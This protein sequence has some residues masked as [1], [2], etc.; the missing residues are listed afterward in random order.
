MSFYQLMKAD[1]YFNNYVDKSVSDSYFNL[2]KNF[3]LQVQVMEVF[4]VLKDKLLS[5]KNQY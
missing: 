4:I 3:E 5:I 2:V 1:Y